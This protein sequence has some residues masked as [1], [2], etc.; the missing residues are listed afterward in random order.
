M[1]CQALIEITYWTNRQNLGKLH[2]QY[3]AMTIG[4]PS[5]RNNLVKGMPGTALGSVA[6]SRK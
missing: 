2:L 3:L 4:K 6:K 1:D 5:S